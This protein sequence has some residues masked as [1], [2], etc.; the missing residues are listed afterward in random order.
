MKLHI[1][2]RGRVVLVLETE[3]LTEEEQDLVRRIAVNSPSI[4]AYSAECNA[5]FVAYWAIGNVEGLYRRSNRRGLPLRTKLRSNVARDALRETSI[6]QTKG[7]G[8]R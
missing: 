8:E 1:E 2:H 3:D 5:E 4:K 7:S 6:L